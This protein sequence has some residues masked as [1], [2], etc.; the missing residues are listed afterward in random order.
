VLFKETKMT[1]EQFETITIWQAETFPDATASS[2]VQ[3]LKEEVEELSIDVAID[4]TEKELEFADC[5]LLLFGAAAKSGMS[6]E[7]ICQAIDRKMEI[8]K[9]RQWGK[10]DV[11]GVVK[12]VKDMERNTP[13]TIGELQIG[14][15]FYKCSDKKKQVWEKVESEVKQTHFQTYRHFAKQPGMRFP[16]PMNKATAV[17]FLRHKEEA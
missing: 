5:F 1:K 7:S 14:D 11:N 8:N 13:T 17:I 6:Y 10:P 9:K 4:G 3:H 15:R 12:H 16:Q 2:K